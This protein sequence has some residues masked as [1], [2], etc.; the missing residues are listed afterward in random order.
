V[1]IK[2]FREEKTGGDEIAG[3]LAYLL[4]AAV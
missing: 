3:N 1:K 4:L 2:V